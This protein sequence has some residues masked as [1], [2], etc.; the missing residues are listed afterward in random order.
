MVFVAMVIATLGSTSLRANDNDYDADADDDWGMVFTLT[1]DPAGNHLAMLEV[2]ALGELSTPTYF[3][4]GGNGLNTGLGSQGALALSHDRQYLF[5]CN[6]GSN[7]IAVFRLAHGGPNFMY[8]TKSGGSHPIS[9]TVH[10][11][12][13]YVLNAG[14]TFGGGIDSITG[15]KVGSNGSLTS[16]NNSA[17][18]SA[19]NV[20]PAQISFNAE[21]NVLTVSEKGTN[22]ISLFPVNANSTPGTRVTVPSSGPTP[23]GFAYTN[24]D[25]LIVSEAAGGTPNAS[26]V[27]SYWLHEFHLVLEPVST[28]IKAN[29]TAAC[30]I[31]ITANNKYA[32]AA[33]TGSA[34]IT[35]FAIQP[36]GT[37]TLLESNGTAAT[38]DATPADMAILG[39]QL[40][41]VLD[42]S[43]GKLGAYHIGKDGSLSPTSVATGL[44]L[45]H[46]AGLVVR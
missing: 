18:L 43:V 26:S 7:T 16:L 9:L 34:T 10:K 24:D 12:V 22:S 45:T 44:P 19:T 30:W 8:A 14:G 17:N 11:N 29:Q 5:A 41:F 32:Y 46:P 21:G 13:L 23:F 33:N 20:G 27:S 28:S 35:G 3:A 25:L 40:L 42:G 39:N 2:N 37:L 6:A 38:T 36:H 15:F 1:N 31:A 4:T